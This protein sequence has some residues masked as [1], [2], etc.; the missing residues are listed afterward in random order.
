MS[1]KSFITFVACVAAMLFASCKHDKTY[2]EYL[3]DE[4]DAIA[5]YMKENNI[6]VVNTMPDSTS[7]WLTEEG[8]P[9][10]YKFSDGLY[11]HLVDKGDTT[12]LAPKT[13][14]MVFVRYKGVNMRG[15]VYYDCSSSVSANPQSFR[16]LN[17]PTSDNMF[18][19]GFQKAVRSLYAG[20]HCKTIIP[21]KI[22][23]G[24][25]QNIYGQTLS[26]RSLYRTMAYEIWLT[27]VE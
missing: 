16:I 19:E 15:G 10:Y 21:F 20:G 5:K 27:R 6:K 7:E 3:E 24:M 11:F 26:D 18:G 17:N 25:N 12:T 4:H 13:G 23:N 22:G 9:V 14:N 8:Y 2:A 1:L